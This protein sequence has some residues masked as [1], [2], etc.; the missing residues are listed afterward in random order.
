MSA[1]DGMQKLFDIIV[2][3]YKNPESVQACLE[4]FEKQTLKDFRVIVCIN[5]DPTEIL[6]VID[7]YKS[8]GVVDVIGVFFDDRQNHGRS[9]NRNQGLKYLE[10]KYSMYMDSDLIPEP[11]LLEQHAKQLEKTNCISLGTVR[12]TNRKENIWAKYQYHTGRGKFKARDVIPTHYLNTQ[13]VAMDTQMLI[14]LDGQWE[15]LKHYGGDDTELGYRIKKH[16]NVPLVYNPY[17]AATSEMDKQLDKA[18]KDVYEF[19]KYNMPKIL[20]KHPEFEGLYQYGR[21]KSN[22]L[23]RNLI[24]L[25]IDT[26]L[27]G[28]VQLA[29][30]SIVHYLTIS[31]IYKGLRDSGYLKG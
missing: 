16:Y 11:D 21:Y 29:P 18:L 23:L 13:N 17:A 5:D 19:G 28:I 26:L 15:G 20:I 10:A 24:N 6:K 25:P 2:P 12:Y 30:M 1:N 14:E 3:S 8:R 27:K 22:F 4:G 31:A 7:Q 9:A